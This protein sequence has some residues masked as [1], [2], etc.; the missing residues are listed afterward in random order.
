[1]ITRFV[2]S[3]AASAVLLSACETQT[4]DS[5]TDPTFVLNQGVTVPAGVP[6]QRIQERYRSSVS[7]CETVIRD[8]AQ[9]GRMSQDLIDLNER[10]NREVPT[11]TNFDFDRDELRP[12]ARAIL[13]QQAAWIAMYPELH[14]SAFGHTDLVG[15]L[16]YN[17]DLAKRRADAVVNYLIAR[18]I[19]AERLES[20]VSFGKTQPVIQ[21]DLP[22]ERNRRVVTEVSGYLVLK[23]VSLVPV[24]CN[25]ID[26]SFAASYPQC[27][28]SVSS[29]PV[30]IP[31]PEPAEPVVVGVGY[32][33][34]SGD[35]R[36]GASI[37]DDG[38]GNRIAEAS[39]ET[40]PVEAPRTT[41]E[42]RS[43]TSTEAPSTVS[44]GATGRAGSVGVSA[45]VS[46]DGT[47]DPRSVTF[48]N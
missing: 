21:T 25:V 14:F 6:C 40:G 4:N 32:D 3:M 44:A 43:E 9:V 48:G 33:N 15:S 35:S 39:G 42:A 20:V 19:G 34:D 1:M 8:P 17:F 27:I 29:P 11:V 7:G 18:G 24:S 47:I 37:S 36:G 2:F 22:E 12:D 31:A 28:D 45:T 23:Q 41:T 30:V 10:F 26:V 16:D 38:R 46:D 5:M 13:D